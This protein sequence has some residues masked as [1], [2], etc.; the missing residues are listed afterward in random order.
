MNK[1]TEVKI[2]ELVEAEWNYK[3]DGTP[4]EIDRLKKAICF[5]KSC[6]VLMVRELDSGKFEVMDG[7]HRLK[8]IRELKW[9][10]VPIENCGKI[11]KAR[12][13]VLTR[14]R[15]E[16]WFKDDRLQLANLYDEFVFPEFGKEELAA[17]TSDEVIDLDIMEQLAKEDGWEGFTPRDQPPETQSIKVDPET[18]DAWKKFKDKIKE[19]D[20]NKALLCAMRSYENTNSQED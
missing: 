5:A 4:E 17:I 6:G 18:Y 14:Q 3:T 1:V 10:K 7:N 20:N 19:K 13:I 15:N 16:Q 9:E 2:S 11:T 12:A 8:A